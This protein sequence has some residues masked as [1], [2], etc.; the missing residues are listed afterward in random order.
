MDETELVKKVYT[1][2][3]ITPCKD[4]WIHQLRDDLKECNILQSESEIKSMK[5]YT[6]R[7][8]KKLKS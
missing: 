1:A 3:K 6:F 8:R 2:Q 7:T 4:D 5:I